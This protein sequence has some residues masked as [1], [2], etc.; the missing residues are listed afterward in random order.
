MIFS[1]NTIQ[2]QLTLSSDSRIVTVV[3][4][5]LADVDLLKQALEKIIKFNDILRAQLVDDVDLTIPVVEY[6][7][8]SNVVL[9][10]YC[11]GDELLPKHWYL[12]KRS[13]DQHSLMFKVL[14]VLF[15]ETS[16]SLFCHQLQ[17]IYNSLVSDDLSKNHDENNFFEDLLGESTIQ[18]SEFTQWLND[19][20]NDEDNFEAKQYW[21]KYADAAPI[22]L[23]HLETF[24]ET[25]NSIKTYHQHSTTVALPDGINLTNDELAV[26]CKL[27]WSKLLCD[28]SGSDSITMVEYYD[29]RHEYDEMSTSMGCFARLAPFHFVLTAEQSFQD[30]IDNALHEYELSSEYIEALPNSCLQFANVAYEF[31]NSCNIIADSNSS[32]NAQ[33][34]KNTSRI[35]FK[36]TPSTLEPPEQIALKLTVS[37][38]VS[39]ELSITVTINN[40]INELAA[41]LLADQFKSI[42]QQYLFTSKDKQFSLNN[43]NYMSALDQSL[44][45]IWINRQT[46][47]KGDV[48][49]AIL[50]A[51]ISNSNHIAI[52]EGHK[53]W[54]YGEV[55]HQAHTLANQ[56]NNTTLNA[57]SQQSAPVAI[58]LGQKAETLICQL[59][60]WM[61]NRAFIVVDIKQPE[62]NILSILQETNAS[63]IANSFADIEYL[64][65]KAQE[66]GIGDFNHQMISYE[67][68]NFASDS[69]SVRDDYDFHRPTNNIPAYILY[70]SG[71]TGKPKG[72]IIGRQQISNYAFAIAEQ[73]GFKQGVHCAVA[74]SLS[75]DLAY[76]CI[77]SAWLQAG[78]VNLIPDQTRTNAI[79][80]SNYIESFKHQGNA[81]E[82]LKIVP[83]H[84]QALIGDTNT[85]PKYL[86]SSGLIFG[87]EKASAT[88]IDAI[89]QCDAAIS[90]YN[91]YGPTETT[92]GVAIGRYN[93]DNPQFLLQRPLSGNTLVLVNNNLE[94]VSTGSI[95]ELAISGQQ[96]AMGYW[97][98]P[99]ETARRFKS[100]MI[101]GKDDLV[102]L[103]GDIARFTINGQLEILARKDQQV[104]VRGFRV[105]LDAICSVIEAQQHVKKALVKVDDQSSQVLIAYIQTTSSTVDLLLLEQSLKQSLA[106]ALPDY[107]CPS[108]YRFITGIPLLAS[109]KID[110]AKIDTCV[111]QTNNTEFVAP[112]SALET[113][114][115]EI[116]QDKLTRK[117][118]GIND[119]F[120]ALGGHSLIAI[121]IAAALSQ[122]VNIV[123]PPGIVFENPTP[124]DLSQF[125]LAN[126]DNKAKLEAIA[127]ARLKLR[128]MSDEE[129]AV[130]L[131]QRHS[132]EPAGAV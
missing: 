45:D 22:S 29:A 65:L 103:T 18:Y 34:K 28:H 67:N 5:G 77:F 84:F 36:P 110:L 1:L 26:V 130:L 15:D 64:R 131:A 59:A 118:I 89:H 82:F 111:I 51:A 8:E 132:Q 30:Y 101:N 98:L 6:L 76:T 16:E 95:G 3:I 120:F 7:A 69:S 33:S 40:R 49:E 105:E 117:P 60:S 47:Y 61:A 39:G 68:L 116:W 104:K 97:N 81:I 93:K 112:Q 56:L 106:S 14:N 2:K 38:S 92:V 4:N 42:L 66:Q 129:K 62:S 83:G 79:A 70:T 9:K 100:L 99:S 46:S 55:V 54:T 123:L 52:I 109:G 122:Q 21:A 96:V 37:A 25:L 115:C 74:S 27:L 78:C 44:N 121:K 35:S 24:D 73:L 58:L 63:I 48:L 86:P 23:S 41:T 50:S 10:D 125:L 31:K 91:H 113:L 90:I 53:Q 85:I 43:V 71:T 114:V 19:L 80:F 12:Q 127:K 107:M 102:Y 20:E 88:L 72:V 128:N 108:Q 57:N 94:P 119:D 75:T 11:E 124:S 17:V 13:E 126:S 87:G 32:E